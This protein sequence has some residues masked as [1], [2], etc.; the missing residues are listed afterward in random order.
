MQRMNTTSTISGIAVS[1][2]VYE[3]NDPLSNARWKEVHDFFTKVSD[4]LQNC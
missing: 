1:D 2:E 3:L 4:Y